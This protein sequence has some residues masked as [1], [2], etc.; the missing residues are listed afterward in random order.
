MPSSNTSKTDPTFLV[1]VGF[2]QADKFAIFHFRYGFSEVLKISRLEDVDAIG[3]ISVGKIEIKYKNNRYHP[4]GLLQ[5]SKYFWTCDT[6]F[7]CHKCGEERC[8]SILHIYRI[9][10]HSLSIEHHSC[11]EVI[12]QPEVVGFGSAWLLVRELDDFYVIDLDT[13]TVM[14]AGYVPT[15]ASEENV[16]A[17]IRWQQDDNDICV[18]LSLFDFVSLDDDGEPRVNVFL[19]FVINVD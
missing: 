12:G 14:Y 1:K 18:V 7:V 9:N 16:I 17:D 15:V 2:A 6:C 13:T 19:R 3:D 4:S 11:F 8:S 5:G 10:V